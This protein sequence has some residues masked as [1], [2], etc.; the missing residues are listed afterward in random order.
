[1][2]TFFICLFLF[3]W[4]RG[5]FQSAL[6]TQVQIFED[7]QYI[8]GTLTPVIT[9][10]FTISCKAGESVLLKAL[11]DD[12]SF[13]DVVVDCGHPYYDANYDLLKWVPKNI[14][15]LQVQS[16][17]YSSYIVANDP[18]YISFDSQQ[19]TNNQYYTSQ[20]PV[21]RKRFYGTPEA[22]KEM[23]AT[24]KRYSEL[25]P[26]EADLSGAIIGISLG[27]AAGAVIS[28]SLGVSIVASGI[29]RLL[30]NIVSDTS[31]YSD[32]QINSILNSGPGWAAC[33]SKIRGTIGNDGM[34]GCIGQILTTIN[35]QEAKFQ[36][37][38]NLTINLQNQNLQRDILF[39]T[40]Q[41]TLAAMQKNLLDFQ[42]SI[43]SITDVQLV[44][45]Y[46]QQL[47]VDST[48]ALAAGLAQVVTATNINQQQ[49]QLLIE[50]SQQSVQSGIQQLE[51]QFQS[52]TE[53]A[54][55]QLTLSQR[56]QAQQ[57]YEALL[58]IKLEMQDIQQQLTLNSATAYTQIQNKIN[59]I[60]QQLANI[61]AALSMQID[62]NDRAT[63][64]ISDFFEFVTTLGTLPRDYFTGIDMITQQKH[65]TPFVSDP[66]TRPCNIS[67]P[68]L[69]GIYDFTWSTP[70]IVNTAVPG[71]P[72]YRSC[73]TPFT[74]NAW[75]PLVEAQIAANN[76][77][78]F[79]VPHDKNRNYVQMGDQ[80]LL[81]VQTSNTTWANVTTHGCACATGS[82]D[83]LSISL[84]VSNDA[85]HYVS[86]YVQDYNRYLLSHE[87]K[88]QIE[89]ENVTSTV[90][91]AKLAFDNQTAFIECAL[92]TNTQTG[93][94]SY[95][96]QGSDCAPL[97]AFIN[98]HPSAEVNVTADA[99]FATCSELYNNTCQGITY[100]TVCTNQSLPL[101]LGSELLNPGDVVY[102]D[103]VFP[104]NDYRVRPCYA[105]QYTA[106]SFC[107][108]DT[109]FSTVYQ[110]DTFTVNPANATLAAAGILFDID[111]DTPVTLTLGGAGALFINGSCIGASSIGTPQP[112]AHFRFV[113][114]FGAPGTN[115]IDEGIPLKKRGAAPIAPPMDAPAAP[116]H[117][118]AYSPVNCTNPAVMNFVTSSSA[119]NETA[120]VVC[121]SQ[122]GCVLAVVGRKDTVTITDWKGSTVE[123]TPGYYPLTLPDGGFSFCTMSFGYGGVDIVRAC[124]D[125]Y[126]G[127]MKQVTFTISAGLRVSIIE[128]YPGDPNAMPP[129][130]GF[131]SKNVLVSYIPDIAWTFTS[132]MYMNSWGPIAPNRDYNDVSVGMLVEYD[133]YFPIFSYIQVCVPDVQPTN[134]LTETTCSFLSSKPQTL[135]IRS[136]YDTTVNYQV[137][138]YTTP[139]VLVYGYTTTNAQ[140][141][142]GAATFILGP[143]GNP[144]PTAFPYSQI[145]NVAIP[146]V[147]PIPGALVT[148]TQ[149][150]NIAI[151]YAA[152]GAVSR[153]RATCT[154][155]DTD[156][157]VWDYQPDIRQNMCVDQLPEYT[158]ALPV[159]TGTV[160]DSDLL[161]TLSSTSYS[162]WQVTYCYPGIPMTLNITINTTLTST[163]VGRPPTQTFVQTFSVINN[164]SCNLAYYYF[165]H[166]FFFDG[167]F[168][169]GCGQV[170]YTPPV[171]PIES[172]TPLETASCD[173]SLLLLVL[174]LFW[175]GQTFGPIS[176]AALCQQTSGFLDPSNSSLAFYD[177]SGNTTTA[178]GVFAPR[179]FLGTQPDCVWDFLT[180]SCKNY[181]SVYSNTVQQYV[182]C[183]MR[184]ANQNSVGACITSPP[185]NLI[186]PFTGLSISGRCVFII[187]Q[188]SNVGGCYFYSFDTYPDRGGGLGSV[189]GQIGTGPYDMTVQDGSGQTVEQQCLMPN[190]QC[191]FEGGAVIPGGTTQ[192]YQTVN[193][194]SLTYECPFYDNDSPGCLQKTW[195]NGTQSCVYVQNRCV[196]PCSYYNNNPNGCVARNPF[197]TCYYNTETNVCAPYTTYYP[198]L[199]A[200]NNYNCASASNVCNLYQN[201]IPSCTG[202]PDCMWYNYLDQPI[203]ALPNC[204]AKNLNANPE[205]TNQTVIPFT[206]LSYCNVT[207]SM[208]LLNTTITTIGSC[209]ITT[210]VSGQA[211][212]NAC[213]NK[214]DF[215]TGLHCVY[216]IYGD[217]LTL[218]TP[219]NSPTIYKYDELY[220]ETL[221]RTS[222]SYSDYLN[223]LLDTL[224]NT[225]VCTFDY[226]KN[227]IIRPTFTITLE[228]IKGNGISMIPDDPSGLWQCQN[229]SYTALG[230]TCFLTSEINQVSGV[231]GPTYYPNPQHPDAILRNVYATMCATEV[232]AFE[233]VDNVLTLI[234]TYMIAQ[235]PTTVAESSMFC[236]TVNVTDPLNFYSQQNYTV[237]PMVNGQWVLD[238]NIYLKEGLFECSFP[239]SKGLASPVVLNAFTPGSIKAI[240]GYFS[241][242][243]Y[244][245]TL[246]P[247][248]EYNNITGKFRDGPIVDFGARNFTGD[249]AT[250][251][252]T[253][254]S[255]NVEAIIA[256]NNELFG[257]DP[258]AWCARMPLGGVVVEELRIPQ[259]DPSKIALPTLQAT[260]G[261]IGPLVPVY[262]SGSFQEYINSPITVMTTSGN[263]TFQPQAY[264][265]TNNFADL[266]PQNGDCWAQYID[267]DLKL[268][269][270]TPYS[271]CVPCDFSD[272]AGVSTNSADQTYLDF[273][274]FIS[275]CPNYDPRKIQ[276][277][278]QLYS[279]FCKNR[280][281][282]D[283]N[284]PLG[285]TFDSNPDTSNSILSLLNM[286]YL[287]S[288]NYV[289]IYNV[290]LATAWNMRIQQDGFLNIS[291]YI[292]AF[293]QA[294]ESYGCTVG[295]AN[296][297]PVGNI[298]YVGN[299]TTVLYAQDLY[300]QL[301]VMAK[302][303]VSIGNSFADAVAITSMSILEPIAATFESSYCG[304]CG[305]KFQTACIPYFY[306][307]GTAA[308]FSAQN[309]LALASTRFSLSHPSPNV[310][311]ATAL[312]DTAN[313]L[314][315]YSFTLPIQSLAG[316]TST[317]CPIPIISP[318]SFFECSAASGQNL[319][320]VGMINPLSYAT[321]QVTLTKTVAGYPLLSSTQT[322]WL[323]PQKQFTATIVLNQNT[324]TTLRVL[325]SDSTICESLTD[326]VTNISIIETITT[327]VDAA[328]V[329][330]ITN[331]SSPLLQDIISLQQSNAAFQNQQDAKFQEFQVNVTTVN[332]IFNTSLQN[333]FEEIFATAGPL[334]VTVAGQPINITFLV[335][336]L[337]P[338]V[339]NTNTSAVQ[340]FEPGSIG[341]NITDSIDAIKQ[342][343]D[344]AI[345]NQQNVSAV[346][347]AFTDIVNARLAN[348]TNEFMRALNI[349]P[350]LNTILDNQNT[351]T[352]ATPDVTL[353][354]EIA[355]IASL[356]MSALALVG[357]I[358][359]TI[360]TVVH[361]K[362][363]KAMNKKRRKREKLEKRQQA[364]PQPYPY[365]QPM[366]PAPVPMQFQMPQI[367]QGFAALNPRS[368]IPNPGAWFGGARYNRVG[369]DEG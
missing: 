344:A 341:K 33:E 63:Q 367:P 96:W 19:Y 40:L 259:E 45:N 67:E 92:T 228:N 270:S 44:Q 364:Y 308:P 12:G 243:L 190:A 199:P 165:S 66:G 17:Q 257:T 94:C 16:A 49:Q 313:M 261:F 100:T 230:P 284:D 42:Q 264:V 174:Q 235:L 184:T 251:L 26:S 254:T 104:N 322:F 132:T 366:A 61:D 2:K 279:S 37:L 124:F 103:G 231:P 346:A 84:C 258:T 4:F 280:N 148:Y 112:P 361:D 272:W 149:D 169:F 21:T 345:T 180:S 143:I 95:A 121:T 340:A 188:N 64:A 276:W 365:A 20:G 327:A 8:N 79:V 177:I 71:F 315:T 317:D 68:N 32:D 98:A 197:D 146:T 268:T 150:F 138:N 363:E 216:S 267:T 213:V 278:V 200:C 320:S 291:D 129:T 160:G 300:A 7:Q 306:Y 13:D 74:S 144:I 182:G 296:R 91:S 334:Y 48:A 337:L 342:S 330:L 304:N 226:L 227:T 211:Y 18:A 101:S 193:Q 350:V 275:Y 348:Y 234:P 196:R 162:T 163:C 89:F 185:S 106:S 1:M 294:W 52:Q 127:Y 288:L 325:S 125:P 109:A 262:R 299:T 117:K 343:V 58:T 14:S 192:W 359:L 119:I 90:C 30:Q 237:V 147:T 152:C 316:F 122:P 220:G 93:S 352:G 11:L 303:L 102:F 238:S 203:G 115:T 116:K 153:D 273:N 263:V 105:S 136:L 38:F 181:D 172:I 110:Q 85:L 28:P 141:E 256:I 225:F 23:G 41:G 50:Q 335:Q 53:L 250:I 187:P 204:S 326:I 5:T 287:L 295:L 339:F 24:R 161:G 249:F 292:Q 118:R 323:A 133:P 83:P 223:G 232:G 266:L 311:R 282:C 126:V 82:C 135:S 368:Y 46:N 281:V 80:F 332:T 47:G 233:Q 22:K 54:A 87:Q 207:N 166:Q 173:P 328:Y 139:G 210:S 274:T 358:A 69:L 214:I 219:A 120:N 72:T 309:G 362:K 318:T 111:K 222:I 314:L 283:P 369:Q 113:P 99:E 55:A 240:G 170:Y 168:V 142:I 194:T 175:A 140:W 29:G 321:L 353:L 3:V 76:V 59:A 134:V 205:C 176:P 244:D 167:S 77:A 336:K 39:N 338:I 354:T 201:N 154:Q 123:V 27:A 164:P 156:R 297:V 302:D 62:F 221:K 70:M 289:N 198:S 208:G 329:K 293:D 286:N 43:N 171:T 36:A 155:V 245:G 56:I 195:V 324:N 305:P 290:S 355:N 186:D 31:P 15:V 253:K 130:S 298:V 158:F 57:Y 247:M 217:A 9:R 159:G 236:P 145:S 157:C 191:F 75:Q 35:G 310:L 241:V 356:V 260:V 137:L 277:Y 307:T 25:H 312:D 131:A 242:P 128:S 189:A 218:C 215:A 265:V 349:T 360:Y 331:T 179:P 248:V 357:V 252:A 114:I 183:S 347:A 239:Y 65:Q 319:C 86:L 255:Q 246:V 224:T 51:H 108:S 10:T 88:C 271:R 229:A 34:A 81:Q 301:Y 97:V 151:C 212:I 73:E 333:L 202:N 60:L 269:T 285:V 209:A 78:T 206:V 107:L 351:I 178:Y 6:V